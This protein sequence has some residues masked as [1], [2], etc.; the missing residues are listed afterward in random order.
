MALMMP[1]PLGT[2]SG[3]LG[4]CE[5]AVRGGRIVAKK[6]RQRQSSTSTLRAEAQTLNTVYARGWSSLT[7]SMRNAWATAARTHPMPDRFGTRRYLSGFQL[8]S[9]MPRGIYVFGTYWF[10]LSPPVERYDDTFSATVSLA[11]GYNGLI[12]VAAADHTASWLSQVWVGRMRAASGSSRCY[13]W[14]SL[15]FIDLGVGANVLDPM[16]VTKKCKLVAGEH[17]RVKLQHFSLKYWP[18]P[19]DLGLITVV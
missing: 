13:R 10:W 7:E 1:G 11:G 12:W 19:V 14:L 15:G 9:T 2:V 3:R 18:C 17:V 5:F 6:C 8:W 4:G 16:M